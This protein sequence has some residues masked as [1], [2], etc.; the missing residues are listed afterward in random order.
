MIQ[1]SKRGK[2]KYNCQKKLRDG[3]KIYMDKFNFDSFNKDQSVKN[4][5]LPWNVYKNLIE[6]FSEELI[7]HMVNQSMI[8]KAPYNLGEFRIQKKKMPIGLLAESN[9]LKIDYA[10]YL[11]TGIKRKFLNE[12][13]DGY[14]YKFYWLCKKGPIGKN[15]YKYVPLRKHKRQLANVLLTTNK[16]YFE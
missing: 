11:K 2:G 3:Y 9:K 14:R 8:L 5:A 4:I 6:D 10:H 15:V 13:R 12:H 7:D 1:P 16:D